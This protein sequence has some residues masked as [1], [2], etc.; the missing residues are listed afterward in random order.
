MHALELTPTGDQSALCVEMFAWSRC[1]NSTLGGFEVRLVS[2]DGGQASLKMPSGEIRLVKE[3]CRATIGSVGNASHQKSTI[4]K[5]GR[6][7]WKGRRPRVRGV[8]MNPVD[9]PMGGGEGRTSGGGHLHLLGSIVQGFSDKKKV[10]AIQFT[11]TSPPKRQKA[12]I[13]FL[14]DTIHKKKAF[15]SNPVS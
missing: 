7:R 9:H 3:T 6:N 15:S 13:S 5:A 11:N 14:H 10:K 4:G 8:A 12:Q 2:I 1:G